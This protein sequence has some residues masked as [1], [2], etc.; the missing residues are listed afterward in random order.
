M[1]VAICV[2]D[3]KVGFSV[4]ISACMSAREF[5]NIP[6]FFNL[7]INGSSKTLSNAAFTSKKVTA[8]WFFLFGLL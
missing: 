2:W 5:L 6:A 4:N 8:G 7:L 1:Y 3:I